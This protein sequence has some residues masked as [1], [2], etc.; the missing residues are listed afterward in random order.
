VA[1]DPDARPPSTVAIAQLVEENARLREQ[2]ASVLESASWRLT[3]PLR[4]LRGSVR[5]ESVPRA[6]ELPAQPEHAATTHEPPPAQPPAGERVP[7][8]VPPGHF[9]SPIVDP[10]ELVVE[11]RRSRIW[12]PTPRATPGIDWREDEQIA[13]CRDILAL[14]DRLQFRVDAGDDP[15]EYFAMNDQYPPLDAWLLEAMLQ[16]LRPRRMIEVGSGFSSLVT[17]RVNRELFGSQ[18]RFSCIEPYP[19]QFLIDGVPGISGLLRSK[20]ED[21]PL[22]EF[23]SLGSGDILF[24][25]TSHVVKTGGDVTWIFHEIIPR[26]APGVIVQIHD[27]FLPGDYPEAWVAEGRS[28]NES[29][30]VHSFLTFNGVFEIL[31]G[32]QFMAARHPDVLAQA[33]PGWPTAPSRGA[34]ALWIRRRGE[35]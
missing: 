16:W 4:R 33:F 24:I 17:A 18:M 31:L 29:Y 15:T 23:E 22:G 12:P 10:S 3:R 2:L 28:W 1:D 19:R 20:I 6:I 27:I 7:Q 8:F 32:S 35:S 13:L 14:Q 30:L 34:G 11:P 26:L 5:P 25:D 9:Y 21:V